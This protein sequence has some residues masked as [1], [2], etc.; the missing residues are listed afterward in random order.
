MLKKKSLRIWTCNSYIHAQKQH[1]MK[2]NSMLSGYELR[3]PYTGMSRDERPSYCIEFPRKE[4]MLS[5]HMSTFTSNLRPSLF[6]STCWCTV[7]DERI[8]SCFLTARMYMWVGYFISLP[9]LKSRQREQNT[10]DKN[11]PQVW[12]SGYHIFIKGRVPE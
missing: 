2:C 9:V 3:H 1:V 7:D 6:L 10:W 12:V 8:I 4:F 5:D 11:H